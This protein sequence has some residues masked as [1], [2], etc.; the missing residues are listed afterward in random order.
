M[1]HKRQ[2]IRCYTL[3]TFGRLELVTADGV[4]VDSIRPRGLALLALVAASW[5]SGLHRA[6][7]LSM[8]WPEATDAHARN[9]LRQLLF[10]LRSTI[11]TELFLRDQRALKLNVRCCDSD[12]LV[13]EQLLARGRLS[14]ACAHYDG[15]FLDGF[16][17]PDHDEFS[18]FVERR[19][20][21]LEHARRDA[22]RALARGAEQHGAH[23]VA[24]EWWRMLSA[25]DPLDPVS[26]VHQATALERA[27]RIT[28][29][30]SS[31]KAHSLRVERELGVQPTHSVRRM[32]EQ[33]T[34][35]IGES[36]VGGS[37]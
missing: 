22:L 14:E 21:S 11:G 27:G 12:V 4:A 19:R 37:D 33:M 26:A 1:F 15:E 16:S 9:S 8:L 18:T 13:F 30:Y 3:L 5:K 31:L 2:A 17:L 29:A 36:V 7:A 34:N 32:M 25:A 23:G 10:H 6:R 35:R 24:V 28:E 20:E